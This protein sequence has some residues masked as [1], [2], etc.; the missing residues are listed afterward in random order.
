MLETSAQ[1]I[2]DDTG[3]RREGAGEAAAAAGTYDALAANRFE[4]QVEEGG[5]IYDTAHI[6]GPFEDAGDD[7]Y[8]QFTREFKI[9]GT[10]GSENVSEESREAS[11]RYWDDIIAK[12]E[13]IDIP[14]DGNWKG[15]INF[16][17]KIQ[18][19]D[20][21]LAVAIIPAEEKAST[22]RNLVKSAEETMILTEAWFNGKTPQQTHRLKK[23]SIEWEKKYK[24]IE[25]KLYKQETTR[26]LKRK[27]RVEYVP[28]DEAFAKLYDEMFIAATGFKDDII[29]IRFKTK[30]VHFIFSSPLDAKK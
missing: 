9:K 4:Y 7:R 2:A 1:E 22:T 13:N 5:L 30:V 19:L 25:G 20:D 3:T 17:E 12:V 6:F 23:R 29:P 15:L 18:A 21:F 27:A 28:Q 16:Q 14:E 11:M 8:L 26:G 24:R 10:S